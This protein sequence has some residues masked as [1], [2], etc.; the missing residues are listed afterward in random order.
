VR[1]YAASN[2]FSPLSRLLFFSFERFTR[3]IV[4]DIPLIPAVFI[5]MSAFAVLVFY[6]R[7][8]LYSRSFLGFC[9]V[10]CVLLSLVA[11]YGL[12]FCIGITMTSMTQILPFIVFGIGLDDVFILTCSYDRTDRDK[13]PVERIH[14]TI[15]DVG[16][17]ITMTSLTSAMAFALGSIS[18][19]PAIRWLCVYGYP[20]II[21][22][23]LFQL[24]FFVACMVLDEGRIRARRRDC[25]CCRSVL[26]S[27]GSQELE[28]NKHFVDHIMSRYAELLLRRSTKIVVTICFLAVAA[29]LTYSTSKLTQEFEPKDLLPSDSYLREFWD[30]VDDYQ[31]RSGAAPFAYFRWV[32]QSDKDIQKQMNDYVDALVSLDSIEEKPE[33]FWLWDFEEFVDTAPDSVSGLSFAEQMDLFLAEPAYYEM[34]ND[35]I[36]RDDTGT[37]TE[38]RV[39]MFMDNVSWDDVKQQIDALKDQ[40]SLTASQPINQGHSD[41][42]FFTYFVSQQYPKIHTV[43]MKLPT[44]CDFALFWF[45]GRVRH[46][47]TVSRQRGRAHQD[48]RHWSWSCQRH[49]ASAGATLVGLCHYSSF[50]CCLVP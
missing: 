6:R 7:D 34:Y 9:G 46:L 25:C 37:V 14:D 29:G 43:R 28:P 31:A 27:E 11:G 17:S 48:E 2:L 44:H 24:T 15:D 1:T 40:R 4:V 13:D 41:W 12:M 23:F 38:S 35:H 19:I 18:S 50:G 26:P 47:G 49:C 22:V 36:V 21:I 16:L 5:V 42:R 39:L 33:Y 3:S 45:A 10:L 20:T 30:A 8:R 32:D